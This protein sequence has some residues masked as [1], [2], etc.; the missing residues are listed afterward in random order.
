M[1]SV[2][3]MQSRILE[4]VEQLAYV[5]NKDGSEPV[6]TPEMDVRLMTVGVRRKGVLVDRL[7]LLAVAPKTRLCALDNVTRASNLRKGGEPRSRGLA[8][9]VTN[10]RRGYQRLEAESVDDE[11]EDFGFDVLRDCVRFRT[12]LHEGKPAPH[13]ERMLAA[14][15]KR[16]FRAVTVADWEDS[17]KAK[18]IWEDVFGQPELDPRHPHQSAHQSGHQSS[19]HESD[20][21]ELEVCFSRELT[22]GEW[23]ELSP[24][25]PESWRDAA[26]ALLPKSLL[27]PRP[28]FEA[29]A[30][31]SAFRLMLGETGWIEPP[32]VTP[33]SQRSRWT[34]WAHAA[35]WGTGVFLTLSVGFGLVK[36][37]EMFVDGWS[38]PS[39]STPPSTSPSAPPRNLTDTYRLTTED[40]VLLE[41][42]IEECEPFT[43]VPV[44]L[45]WAPAPDVCSGGGG[46]MVCR[47]KAGH[48]NPKRNICYRFGLD[49]GHTF[50]SIWQA[51]IESP[52]ATYCG[53]VCNS[54]RELE[55][56]NQQI[57][58]ILGT[59]HTLS[60]LDISNLDISNLDISTPDTVTT[61]STPPVS[62]PMLP[63]IRREVLRGPK[64]N[65]LHPSSFGSQ[66]ESILANYPLHQD[67]SGNCTECS[68]ESFKH[69]TERD[70]TCDFAVAVCQSRDR[71]GVVK[72]TSRVAGFKTG[73]LNVV[74]KVPTFDE[75]T[76]FSHDCAHACHSADQS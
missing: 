63:W 8:F 25:V 19:H 55:T 59:N 13:T 75:N 67:C 54:K 62:W 71:N 23:I 30:S 46:H 65:N 56:L 24:N 22:E 11:G 28:M 36:A 2:F 64:I 48:G 53:P 40:L 45:R 27:E 44:I 37:V 51:F 58:D 60:T 10:E 32:T 69:L 61:T 3:G 14:G 15:L 74:R 50:R 26:A 42:P 29:E 52:L 7:S 33:M 41:R 21:G 16:M 38:G 17:D 4:L 57:I 43:P 34:K 73:M 49:Q 6:I 1:R 31:D 5:V 47:M 20:Q 18:R 39:P 72:T 9:S 35:K 12:F 68:T 70:C 76:Q 66:A